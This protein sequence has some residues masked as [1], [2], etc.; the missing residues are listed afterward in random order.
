MLSEEEIIINKIAQGKLSLDDGLKWFKNIDSTEQRNILACLRLYLEQSHPEQQLIDDSLEMV[1][2][3]FSVKPIL[4][5]KTHPYKIAA[6]YVCDLSDNELE[7]S[8]ITLLT[9]FKYA[10]TR[11]REL[12]C[13]SSC[14]HEWHNLS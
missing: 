4:L 1:S 2:L 8:F 14:T 10:D 9:L 3:K 12:F 13:K 7:E 6:I 11:R 5:F